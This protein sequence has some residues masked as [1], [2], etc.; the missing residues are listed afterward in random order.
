VDFYWQAMSVQATC[1]LA[2]EQVLHVSPDGTASP[3]LYVLP[4]YWQLALTP[5]SGAGQGAQSTRW[6][7]SGNWEL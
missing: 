5:F 3:L 4:L 2:H 6:Q 7:I 1:P